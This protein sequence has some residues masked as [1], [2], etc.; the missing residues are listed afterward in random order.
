[1]DVIDGGDLPIACDV[2]FFYEDCGGEA[3][4]SFEKIA[5]FPTGVPIVP[6]IDMDLLG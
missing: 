5:L 4:L 6:A 2:Y 1:M 3:A